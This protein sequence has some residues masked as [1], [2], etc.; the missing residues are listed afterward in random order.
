MDTGLLKILVIR[1]SSLGDIILMLP[2][3]N[4]LRAGFPNSRI[5]LAT[6]KRYSGL[7]E[8]N[9]NINGIY[10]LVSDRFIELL[11]LR[12]KIRK[13]KYDIILDAHNV[14]RS[15]FLYH[16]IS[17]NRKIQIRKDHIRKGMLI[18]YKQNFYKEY[19]SQ[20]DKYL[21]LADL[22]G[23]SS[24]KD[25]QNRLHLPLKT[26]KKVEILIE[27]S[28][29][30][31]RELIAVAPGARWD[32]KRWPEERFRDLAAELG[33][34]NFAIVLVGGE[35]E[36]ALAGR[37]AETTHYPIVNTA[38]KLTI[39]ETGAV[40]KKCRLLVTNDSAL[41][42]LSE[43]VETPVAA[44]FGPTVKAFGYYPRM[45]ES[46][47]IEVE[48]DCRP[49]SRSGSSLCPLGTKECLTSIGVAEVLKTIES[50]LGGN[51]GSR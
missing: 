32:T 10:T 37:I 19:K 34:R 29:F 1:F 48:L 17:A 30:K 22:L 16:T 13:N 7:F 24:L 20:R 27:Q 3:L 8:E 41:L 15:N 39:L 28:N 40:L 42:H 31:D 51:T 2:L 44:L 50:I 49:C 14:I 5:D 46:A 43:Q 47:A 9:R 11:R 25:E 33:K 35:E 38:G 23:A 18:K 21:E 26:I 4:R 45:K 12:K 36:K 6:K